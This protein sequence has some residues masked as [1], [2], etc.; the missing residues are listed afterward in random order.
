MQ[1]NTWAIGAWLGGRRCRVP[2]W[3]GAMSAF[4]RAPSIHSRARPFYLKMRSL[5]ERRA[6]DD[7]LAGEALWARVDWI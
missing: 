5:N 6:L 7:V 4:I 1:L 3:F 2:S